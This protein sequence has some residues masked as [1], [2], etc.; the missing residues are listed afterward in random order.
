MRWTAVYHGSEIIKKKL[1]K[2]KK[3]F[4]NMATFT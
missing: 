4:Y 3:H 2:Y 1:T